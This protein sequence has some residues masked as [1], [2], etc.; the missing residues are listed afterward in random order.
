MTAASPERIA[1]PDTT[2]VTGAAGWLGQA[3]VDR[4]TAPTVEPVRRAARDRRPTPGA[5]D[6]PAGVEVVVGDVAAPDGLVELF[7]GARRPRWT[8]ST[9]PA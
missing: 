5:L 2:I 1:A 6:L 8:W 3:L 4:L 7:S 9:P